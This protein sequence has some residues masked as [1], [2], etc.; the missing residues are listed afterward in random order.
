MIRAK[1]I[2]RFVTVLFLTA[3]VISCSSKDDVPKANN[4]QNN[5]NSGNG[6]SGGGTIDDPDGDGVDTSVEIGENTDPQDPCS[7][8]LT[9]Q[10]YTLTT[11]EWRELDCDGDGVINKDEV[12]PDGNAQNEG[13]GT[14][15]LDQCNLNYLFQTV[16]PSNEWKDLNCDEDCFLN[17]TEYLMGTNPTNP[18]LAN[19]GSYLSRIYRFKN[20]EGYWLFENN[21]SQ[22][23]GYRTN[24]FGVI[25]SSFTYIN[26]KLER[27]SYGESE[28]GTFYSVDFS[29]NGDQ[30]SSIDRNGVSFVVEYDNNLITATGTPPFTPPD[31][32]LTKIELDSSTEKVIGCE[33]Y[34]WDN[35]SNYDY[36][37]YAYSYDTEGENLIE[38]TVER[39][40][41]DSDTGE[42]EFVES[43]TQSYE[44]YE[45]ILNPTREASEKLI[46]P[47]LL[48]DKPDLFVENWKIAYKYFWDMEMTMAST[49]LIKSSTN[50]S[51]WSGIYLTDSCSETEGRPRIVYESPNLFGS[52]FNYSD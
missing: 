40:R 31:L 22:Y 8:V 19:I 4:Q 34:V 3:L 37:V 29:Y 16:S 47:A 30:I 27:V 2:I 18:N 48:I 23:A 9:S 10:D 33:K 15:P 44:Y 38:R 26:D 20:F 14:D 12:D 28:Q 13:N 7:Y 25:S 46:I 39:S 45:N 41:Y 6:G 21:G 36:F 43:Y 24:A 11:Q 32:F 17:G 50:T 35:G 5:N 51:P 52:I 1:Y 42:Y 49:N